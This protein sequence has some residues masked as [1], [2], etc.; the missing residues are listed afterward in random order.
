MNISN[1]APPPAT[2]SAT[3]AQV[4]DVRMAEPAHFRMV[5]VSFLAAG[6]G[7]VA[8][9]IAFVLYKLI[10]L[11]TNLFFFHRWSADFSSAQHNQLGWLVIVVPVIGGL[12]VLGRSGVM[13]AR[14][15][16]FQDEHVREPGW[17]PLKSGINTGN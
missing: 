11:F 5:L 8:G 1:G 4:G 3:G 15:R 14:L 6:I 17:F 2:I 10:G 9:L 12:I 16:R 13:A 7:L